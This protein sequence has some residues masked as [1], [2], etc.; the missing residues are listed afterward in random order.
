M[1]RKP[2]QSRLEM[3][4]LHLVRWTCG[5]SLRNTMF[6]TTID[7]VSYVLCYVNRYIVCA[8]IDSVSY[9]LCYVNRYIVCVLESC[10]E[11]RPGM[12]GGHQ[13]CIDTYT[14]R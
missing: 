11:G 5:V 3:T 8:T 2:E 9:V 7:S 4:K 14:G 1:Q 13:M 10:A 6:T 12:R